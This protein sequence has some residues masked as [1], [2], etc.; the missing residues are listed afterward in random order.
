MIDESSPTVSAIASTP[1][2][3][4]D[5][6]N[7]SREVCGG[8][9]WWKSAENEHFR[10]GWLIEQ[11]SDGLAFLTR[12]AVGPPT[13]TC[14]AVSTSDPTEIGF[15]VQTRY[16]TRMNH[17]HADLYFVAAQFKDGNRP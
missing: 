10:Q 12:G 2:L 8:T 6:R 3:A 11:S 16:V 17:I 7:A 14:V 15:R 9:I 13:G 5:R 1:S 4:A